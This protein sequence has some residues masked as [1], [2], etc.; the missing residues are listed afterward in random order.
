VE[1]RWIALDDL[2]WRVTGVVNPVNHQL[3]QAPP[4]ARRVGRITVD[5]P[6]IWPPLGFQSRFKVARVRSANDV[7]ANPV[8][9]LNDEHTPRAQHRVRR[10]VN[11]PNQPEIPISGGT[12]ARGG[13]QAYAVEVIQIIPSKGPDYDHSRLP[14][15]TH[16]AISAPLTGYGNL[17]RP[18]ARHQG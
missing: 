3:I 16:F 14:P 11:V 15:F 9:V 7:T 13:L 6:E 4:C 2:T 18:G 17:P 1:V 8:A 5:L 12:P 10:G